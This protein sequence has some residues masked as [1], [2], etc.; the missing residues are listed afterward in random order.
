MM[1]GDTEQTLMQA[2]HEVMDAEANYAAGHLLFLASRFA[3]DAS[4]SGPGLD[5]VKAL[6]GAYG[7]TLTSTLWRF[8]EQGHGGRPMVA[9]VSGHPHRSKLGRASVRERVCQYV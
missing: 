2:C 8:V 5:F 4:G 3:A 6:S 1:L 7:N 9:L